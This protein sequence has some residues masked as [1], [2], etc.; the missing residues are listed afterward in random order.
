MMIFPKS[1]IE[2]DGSIG[3]CIHIQRRFLVALC[4]SFQE[5]LKKAR[6]LQTC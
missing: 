6:Y 5:D 1:I 4:N 3:A 2:G